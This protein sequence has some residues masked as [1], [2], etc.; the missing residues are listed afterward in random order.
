MT[1]IP[2]AQQS[3]TNWMNAHLKHYSRS[4]NKSFDTILI[5]D[6]LITGFVCYSKVWNK[7]FKPLNT[8]NCGI[9]GNRVQHVLWRAHDLYCFSLLRNVF[10]LC[11]TSNLHQDSPEDIANGL[12]KIA[13]CFEQGSNAINVFICGILPC[14]DTSLLNC[15]LIKETSNMLKSCSVHS[16]RF[17]D[18]DVNWIQMNGSLKPD[19]F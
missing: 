19:L 3:K 2:T 18:Q 8:F 16:I 9:G 13:S 14:D 7:F 4:N 17:I 10:I 11:G 15:Q 1:A 5:G 12:I 6:S